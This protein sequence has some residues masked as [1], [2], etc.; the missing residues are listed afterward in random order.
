MDVVLRKPRRAQGD[1]DRPDGTAGLGDDELAAAAADVDD[2]RVRP[3]TPAPGHA[4][5][6]EHRLFVMVEDVEGD[7]GARLHLPDE[8][9]GVEGAADGLRPDDGD[10]PGAGRLAVAA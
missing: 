3:H 5:E 4:E 7:V 10:L 2:E 6:R 1:A 9:R 8:R